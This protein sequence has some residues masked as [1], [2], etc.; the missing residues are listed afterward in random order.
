MSRFYNDPMISKPNF[1]LEL[2]D[3]FL[4]S[5]EVAGKTCRI[6][7]RPAYVYEINAELGDVIGPCMEVDVLFESG[8]GAVDGALGDLPDPVLDGSLHIASE[9]TPSLIPVPFSSASAVTLKLFMW[10]DYREIRFSANGL[11]IRLDG[12]PRLEKSP[13]KTQR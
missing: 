8:C 6:S 3:S 7:L 5:V 12:E 1:G 11:T 9:P 2:H 4:D 13:V 10:P